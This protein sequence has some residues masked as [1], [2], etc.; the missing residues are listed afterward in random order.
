MILSFQ[1]QFMKPIKDGHKVHTIR[2]D[3]ANR[4]KAGNNLEAY[5]GPYWKGQKRIKFFEGT[6]HSTQAITIR[7][8]DNKLHR[9]AIEV[10]GTLLSELEC[11]H[12]A[13]NDGFNSLDDFLKWFDD[14]F[15][16]KIIHWTEL[17]Y[18]PTRDKAH[19][20]DS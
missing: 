3:K 5:N 1:S 12:L 7:Y 17:K 4:W 15:T 16:G 9:P 6:C 8:G 13:I 10:D 18:T 2:V 11:I 20:M 19:A 14:D